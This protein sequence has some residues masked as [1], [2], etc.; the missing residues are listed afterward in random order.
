MPSA[1]PRGANSGLEFR[2]IAVPCILVRRPAT[3]SSVAPIANGAAA[4]SDFG[5]GAFIPAPVGSVETQFH[6]SREGRSISGGLALAC[7]MN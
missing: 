7:I 6:V 1:G 3:A 5:A 2:P 4:D